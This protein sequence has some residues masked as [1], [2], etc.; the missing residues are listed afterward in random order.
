MVVDGGTADGSWPAS[1]RGPARTDGP[2]AHDRMGGGGQPGGVGLI[3]HRT[4]RDTA[5][6]RETPRERERHKEAGPTRMS[7]D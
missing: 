6:R 5:T 7:P 1:L 4:R 2:M 3:A